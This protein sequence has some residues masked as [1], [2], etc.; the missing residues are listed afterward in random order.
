M[1]DGLT[2]LH[3]DKDFQPFAEHFVSM[4]RIQKPDVRSAKGLEGSRSNLND[5]A[6][7]IMTVA[8]ATALKLPLTARPIQLSATLGRLCPR[9]LNAWY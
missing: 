8:Y 7:G 1:E 4:W 9:G 2:L 5:V 6:F 3:A